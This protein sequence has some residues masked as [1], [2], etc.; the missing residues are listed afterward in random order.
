[1]PSRR[2]RARRRASARVGADPRPPA[3]PVDGSRPAGRGDG[4]VEG[5]LGPDEHEPGADED[6]AE[7][8]VPETEEPGPDDDDGGPRRERARHP[9]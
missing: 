6:E 8:L 4:V 5:E 1:M 7:A 2:V 3:P 9:E